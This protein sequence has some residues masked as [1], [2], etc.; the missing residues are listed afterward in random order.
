MRYHEGSSKAYTPVS[1]ALSPRTHCAALTLEDFADAVQKA[2]HKAGKD[3]KFAPVNMGLSVK[4]LDKSRT[5][6]LNLDTLLPKDKAISPPLVFAEG[7]F[8]RD[9]ESFAYKAA[10]KAS[11]VKVKKAPKAPKVTKPKKA[12]NVKVEEGN[13]PSGIMAALSMGGKGAKGKA[14]KAKPKAKPVQAMDEED[15]DEEEEDKPVSRGS[16]GSKK[17][18]VNDAIYHPDSFN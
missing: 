12:K 9:K 18:G 3:G 13:T 15:L 10:M 17:G 8:D 1:R 6:W 2:N 11:K 4:Y 5:R 16:K 14:A 7:W